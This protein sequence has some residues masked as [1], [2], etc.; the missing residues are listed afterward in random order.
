MAILIV[1]ESREVRHLLE[2]HLKAGGCADLLTAGSVSEALTYLAGPSTGATLSIDLILMDVAVSDMD[3][4][5]ACGFFRSTPHLCDIPI[6][7][8]SDHH[9][10]AQLEASFDAGAFDYVPAPYRPTELHARIRAALRFKSETEARRR[11]EAEL[12]QAVEELK[13]IST[14]DAL[15]TI[16]NRRRFDQVLSSELHAAIRR[17][18]PL[19]LLMIDVDHFKGYNDAYGHSAGDLCLKFV[20]IQIKQ[21]LRRSTDVAARYGGEEFAVI[22]PDTDPAGTMAVAERIRQRIEAL[23]IPNQ[24]SAHRLVTI[25]VGGVAVVPERSSNPNEFTRAA[26]EALYLS[27]ANGRNCAHVVSELESPEKAL[28]TSGATPQ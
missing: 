9:E 16:A 25:S 12:A 22:L 10:S 6:I 23:N 24:R 14:E 11:K 1:K 19:G 8:L 18:S 5:A 2:T 20:G 13:R 21:T 7:M 28:I 17:Q 15:T 3:G 26:D 27:K 4:V